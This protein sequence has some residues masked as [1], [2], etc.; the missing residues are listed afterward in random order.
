MVKPFLLSCLSLVSALAF[1]D[2][3]FRIVENRLYI[4]GTTDSPILLSDMTKVTIR[5]K[6]SKP[7]TLSNVSDIIVE[8]TE[9][10]TASRPITISKFS[11]VLIRNSTFNALKS[12]ADSL[13]AYGE[14]LY[15]NPTKDY[16]TPYKNLWGAGITFDPTKIIY[17]EPIEKQANPTWEWFNTKSYTT[18]KTL[19]V[20][21]DFTKYSTGL[22]IDK[23]TFT[24]YKRAGVFLHHIKNSTVKNSTFVSNNG[25]DSDYDLGA[26]WTKGITFDNNTTYGKGIMSHYHFMNSI[27]K[28]NTCINGD[29]IINSQGDPVHNIRVESNQAR[30]LMLQNGLFYGFSGAGWVSDVI[31]ENGRYGAVVVDSGQVL[32]GYPEVRIRDISIRGI[33][34]DWNSSI[35]PVAL[36]TMSVLDID[37]TNVTILNGGIIQDFA[38]GKRLP[39]V[40]RI[41]E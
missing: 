11:N 34:I 10:T 2:L 6:T 39:T 12:D 25:L 18:G 19:F 23:C 22:V 40:W 32:G 29:I 28:N 31:V 15:H 38:V 37:A 1:S 27:I 13:M 9:V 16:F 21:I 33:T 7:I 35:Y 24:N 41:K 14:N 4:T 26:E 17:G 36:R 8:D 5:V 20:G 30:R 3:D